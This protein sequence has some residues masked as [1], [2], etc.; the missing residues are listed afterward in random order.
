[1]AFG[2]G[3]LT[4]LL[5]P[6]FSRI[7]SLGPPTEFQ[8]C[9]KWTLVIGRLG[10]ADERAWDKWIMDLLRST[11]RH[12]GVIV[13]GCW[14]LEPSSPSSPKPIRAGNK[15]RWALTSTHHEHQGPQRNDTELRSNRPRWRR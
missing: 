8:P 13:F 10:W 3:L 7:D 6:P 11:T 14:T 9:A 15:D 1:M 4:T 5:Q 12:C 2:F